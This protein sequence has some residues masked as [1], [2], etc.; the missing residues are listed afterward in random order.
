MIRKLFDI[1]FWKFILVGVINTLVGT[2][3]M[4]GCYN[5]LHMSYWV[6]SAANYVVGSVVS[7]FLN[8]NFTFRNKSKDPM[9]LV[10]FVVNI[11]VCYLLAYGIAKP[12]V[13]RILS[14]S[15]VRIQENGAMLVG[16]CLFVGLNYL[17]QRFF[18]FREKE[19]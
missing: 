17:G 2:A 11:T 19:D 7:Y 9:V 12:L 3:V 8:K 5:L 1:T 15:S 6:S 18:A 13:R 14:G 4:F 16:M 10:R